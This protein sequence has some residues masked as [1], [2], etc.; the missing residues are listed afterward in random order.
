MFNFEDLNYKGKE[1]RFTKSILLVM[2]ILTVFSFS[3][4]GYKQINVEN[5][6][7]ILKSKEINTDIS[8]KVYII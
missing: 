7:Q 3:Y 4:R 8:R 6:S 2:L 5:F 1:D